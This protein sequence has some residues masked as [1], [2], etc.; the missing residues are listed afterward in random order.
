MKSS[1]PN[2]KPAALA[3]TERQPSYLEFQLPRIGRGH[4]ISGVGFAPNSFRS[5][6]NDW[7][8]LPKL[9]TNVSL[10]LDFALQ[11]KRAWTSLLC[12][13]WAACSRPSEPRSRPPHTGIL[14]HGDPTILLIDSLRS[15]SGLPRAV[16]LRSASILP[17]NTPL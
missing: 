11:K 9:Y 10:K 3:R 6:K 14:P 1:L 7:G 16:V 17:K 8:E 4:P 12:G 5:V 15:L 2:I 13:D